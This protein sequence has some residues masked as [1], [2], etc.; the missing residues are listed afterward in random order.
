MPIRSSKTGYIPTLDGWRAI[1][2]F[3]VI[4]FH[5]Q[6]HFLGPL[7]D[8]YLQHYGSL[9]VDLFFAIS[10]IL[11]CSRLLEEEQSNKRISLRGFYVRRFF[12]ILPP[13]FLFLIVLGILG[14]LHIVRVGLEP[15]ISSV[16]FVNNYDLVHLR[17][18]DVSLYTNHFWSLAI[19]EHF[20]L[21]LPGF[22]FLFCKNRIR[23][24]SVLILAFLAYTACIHF[25]RSWLEYMGGAFADDRTELRI[26]ALLFP[27]LVAIMLRNQQVREFC[28]RR[29]T[30]ISVLIVFVVVAG[31]AHRVG[32]DSAM[33]F[34]VPFG[35]PFIVISTVLHPSSFLSRILEFAPLR[36]LGRISYSL[37]LWQQLFFIGE[38]TSFRAEWPL[39]I[40]QAWPWNYLAVVLVASASFYLIE[41]PFIRAGHR[42]APP[43]TPGR[44]DLESDQPSKTSTE[45]IPCREATEN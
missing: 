3:T 40:L 41:K 13:A 22:L 26:D 24:L 8:Y 10:G 33:W 43:V 17:N 14:G 42:L 29:A 9:G 36:Y 28:T 16:L 2:V 1:A 5:A 31:I 15:W 27:A 4:A 6:L 37:Y 44:N 34:A 20:Y 18:Y 23:V 45:T 35:F 38:H 25:N 21:F 30:T 7:S 19:E 32:Y 39:S 11:I 12:R